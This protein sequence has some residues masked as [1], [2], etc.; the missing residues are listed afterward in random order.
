MSNP[1]DYA[2][3]WICAISTEYVAAQ[4]LLDEK[5]GTPRS[6]ARH[7][8]NDY[9]L[10]RIGEHN[11]V[12]AVLPD[13][14]Y[15][16]ASAA[17]VARDMLH[18]FPNVRIGLMVG[19]GGGAPSEKHDIRLGDVVVSAPRDGKG[20]VFQYDFGKT[21]QNQSFQTTGFLNQ[22]PAVLRAAMAGLRAEYESEGHQ[23]EAT[24]CDV[25]GKKPRLRKKYSRPE[26]ASDI[27]Y[28]SNIV[29]PI[30]SQDSCKV[31]CGDDIKK[32]VSRREREEHED[33]PAIHYGLIASANQLMKDAIMRDTLASE[34]GVLCFEMEAAGLMNQFPCLVIR[35]ICDYSDSHKNK[36]WQGYAAMTAAAYAKDL[37]YRIPPNNV[38]AVQKI[39]DV[40]AHALV[41]S[42]IDD[43]KNE[44]ENNKDLAILDWI[45][46][47]N[48]GPQH[49]DF[50]HRRQPGTGQWL[51]ESEEYRTWLTESDKTLFCVGIPGSGKT[52]LTAIV[53]EDLRNRTSNEASIGLAY[54]YCNFKRQDEQG[55]EGLIASLVKQLSRK[56]PCLPD[57]I[58]NLHEKHEKEKTRPSLDELMKALR[59]IATM[60]SKLIIVIDALDECV[61]FSRSR[62]LLYISSLR[63]RASVS[64]FTTSRHIPDIEKE[65]EGSLRREVLASEEDLHRYIEAHM[66]Y[67]P[68]FLSD[69]NDLK[70]EI[71]AELIKAA[72][73]M[74]LLVN[75]SLESLRG[76]T[77]RLEVKSTLKKL[78]SQKHE[79]KGQD[80]LQTALEQAYDEAMDR[81]DRQSPDQQRLGRNALAWI[82][83]AKR[84]LSPLELRH[85]LAVKPEDNAFDADSLREAGTIISVCAGLVTIDEESNVVRLVHYTTQ[86][87]FDR[88]QN[89]LFPNAE[90]KIAA[91][92]CKYLSNIPC[93]GDDGLYKEPTDL[94]QSNPLLDYAGR[95]WGRH[96]CLLPEIPRGVRDFMTCS[97][98][99]ETAARAYF[100]PNLWAWYTKEPWQWD[101]LHLA[102]LFGICKAL[103]FLPHDQKHLE[104]KDKERRTPLTYA[105]LERHH[106]M[107][108]LLI[109]KG[110]SINIE[111]DLH[112]TPL[113]YA[114]K[115]SDESTVRLLLEFRLLLEKGADFTQ[116]LDAL[117]ESDE[118]PHQHG[119]DAQDGGQQKQAQIAQL[120][121][122]KGTLMHLK[123]EDNQRLLFLAARH[124]H[125]NHLQLLL[126]RGVAI[127][128]RDRSGSTALFYAAR[129][130]NA[131]TVRLLLEMGL[132][133]NS[134][135]ENG[136]TPLSLAAT[137]LDDGR[138]AIEGAAIEARDND[139]QTALMKRSRPEIISD[140]QLYYMLYMHGIWMTFITMPLTYYLP[141][142]PTS[143]L[144][145]T[146]DKQ[147]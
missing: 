133:I 31:G 30:D 17:S 105:V 22:P 109:G 60:Y 53:V 130:G 33:N 29:H 63:T 117:Q 144:E 94:R 123:S 146:W 72:Q 112:Y 126:Q 101:G 83:C 34:M 1:E 50:F 84:P 147:L 80:G 85:A 135:D 14:E 136:Q 125:M 43:M 134:Q 2:V 78:R 11:V 68:G 9:T 90:T 61:A 140:E 128:S 67:L 116:L 118:D 77:S 99:V 51:L 138:A 111:D 119:L 93:I 57:I 142:V 121:L 37:L 49:S 73:G 39:R 113:A 143:R 25:L 12:I 45:T 137:S 70:Q 91:F 66:E 55:I 76:T 96:A 88:R 97:T 106:D 5:H 81:I 42:A 114:I 24:I 69:M 87:Y 38:E 98:T 131:D 32:L 18:S 19:I 21:I 35:G 6:V 23:L 92:C 102:A 132:K 107:I 74:F 8:N 104:S 3:G 54:I 46:P 26:Q 89:H 124:G 48:Y 122:E 65:F 58:R 79:E 71:E 103:E 115:V 15:G 36:E 86:E 139:G 100:L 20:G 110:A 75:L 145:I 62:L 13:G 40:L 82:C 28:R 64:L 7:D 16:I 4:S 120:A 59:S 141:K 95:N 27:L 129:A 127:H 47:L 10:G 56:R 44:W 41:A 108:R 52:I